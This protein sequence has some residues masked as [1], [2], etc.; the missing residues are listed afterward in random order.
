MIRHELGHLAAIERPIVAVLLYHIPAKIM[1][2]LFVAVVHP[3][4]V[5]VYQGASPKGWKRVS[6]NKHVVL[7]IT[8]AAAAA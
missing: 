5:V 6:F 7:L 1:E 2:R 4:S 3:A 8:I